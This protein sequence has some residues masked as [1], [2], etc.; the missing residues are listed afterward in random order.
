MCS[1]HVTA[2]QSK[3]PESYQQ[4][5]NLSAPRPPTVQTNNELV[6]VCRD[7]LFRQQKEMSRGT[8]ATAARNSSH[9][10]FESARRYHLQQAVRKWTRQQRHQLVCMF[11][12]LYAIKVL[13]AHGLC[14]TALQ[15]VYK[16]VVITK[17]LYASS[18][19]WGYTSATDRQRVQAF[20]HGGAH[21][22][23]Y[24]SQLYTTDEIT[25]SADDSLF[26]C[27]LH[28]NDHVLHELLSKH[29]DITYNLRTCCHDRKIPKKRGHLAEKNFITRMLYKNMY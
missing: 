7:C 3:T 5:L 14:V 4:L 10:I 8:A 9:P 23:L 19:W 28:K 27:V 1:M 29:V 18:A 20:L 16:S 12:S 21:S 24:L 2:Y 6:I 26:D 25:D 22:G 17:L 11:S 13:R 15:Q